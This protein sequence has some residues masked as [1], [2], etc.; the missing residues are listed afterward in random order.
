MALDNPH[1]KFFK[2][3]FSR[4]DVCAALIENRFPEPLRKRL[5]VTTLEL[6]NSSFVDNELSEHF[7]DL[8]Y[9]CMYSGEKSVKIALLIEHKSYQ[10]DYPHLQLMRYLLNVWQE[11]R[12]QNRKLTPVIPLVIY[13]GQGRWK[14]APFTSYFTATDS[15]LE[16]FLPDF[17]YLLHDLSAWPDKEILAFQN[18][19]LALA[20]FLLKHSRAEK[21]LEQTAQFLQQLQVEALIAA[22]RH[23]LESVFVYIFAIQRP[24]TKQQVFDTFGKISPTM[25]KVANSIYE[26]ALFEGEERLTLEVIKRSIQEGVKTD[27]IARILNLPIQKVEEIIEKIKKGLA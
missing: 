10:E 5:D 27:F 21:F 14:Y 17:R 13:H 15:V 7:A 11:D 25:E 2:S 9:D 8:V 16:E 23:F 1:D 12:K 18:Q 26:Q 24:L 20:T 22:D 3:A 19:F 4:K 6:T